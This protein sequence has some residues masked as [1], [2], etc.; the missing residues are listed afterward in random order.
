MLPPLFLYNIINVIAC[1][2]RESP[3]T[4]KLSQMGS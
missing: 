4:M 1:L 2:V 3:A